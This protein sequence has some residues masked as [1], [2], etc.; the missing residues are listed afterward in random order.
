M[1][2]E[3]E[4][5]VVLRV[6]ENEFVPIHY[7][8]E[9]EEMVLGWTDEEEADRDEPCI[10]YIRMNPRT[11]PSGSGWRVVEGGDAG[12]LADADFSIGLS[13]ALGKLSKVWPRGRTE[14][15][16]KEVA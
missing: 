7:I 4:E 6:A 3:Q 2:I 11:S 9:A 12:V 14:Y 15:W 8:L 5:C 13:D 1:S 10:C 16:R